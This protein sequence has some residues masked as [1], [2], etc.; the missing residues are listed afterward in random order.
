MG[1]EPKPI[2]QKTVIDNTYVKK[3]SFPRLQNYQQPAAVTTASFPDEP[4]SQQV[5]TAPC[6]VLD[7]ILQIDDKKEAEQ[8]FRNIAS[9]LDM[10]MEELP[11]P[12]D[13]TKLAQEE[14]LPMGA[15]YSSL[16]AHIKNNSQA[17]KPEAIHKVAQEIS[18]MDL[19]FDKVRQK[20][21]EKE[22]ATFLALFSLAS[23]TEDNKG[24]WNVT[25]NGK[26]VPMK[27]AQFKVTF[28]Q[29]LDH[30]V[31]VVGMGALSAEYGANVFRRGS[32]FCNDNF[33]IVVAQEFTETVMSG[34]YVG[35]PS[36]VSKKTLDELADLLIDTIYQTVDLNN[37]VDWWTDKTLTAVEILIT[38][39]AIVSG[40]GAVVAGGAKLIRAAY[41]GMI[42]LESSNATDAVVRFLGVREKGY[43][44]LLEAAKMLDKQ[45]GNNSRMIEYTF[46]GLNM[47]MTFG[48]RPSTKI[49]TTLGS[50]I[51]GGGMTY[52]L[53]SGT[54]TQKPVESYEK[55]ASLGGQ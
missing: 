31:Y 17:S 5:Q 9:P 27:S 3:P 18:N 42:I 14:A 28:H 50:G 7:F 23:R 13:P 34:L 21:G 38:V 51:A 15:S 4:V 46:H 11:D 35:K 43:N 36:P 8:A 12:Q 48:K 32:T 30:T 6:Q 2:W 16:M 1:L 53:Q 52:V 19:L 55:A 20:V 26:K 24:K 33:E 44:P 40:V 25:L 22:F 39:A 49:L 45:T 29:R 41:I 54:L 47:M 10:V 37:T